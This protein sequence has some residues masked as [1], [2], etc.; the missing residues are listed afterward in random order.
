MLQMQNSL[1]TLPWIHGQFT[2]E[3][4]FNQNVSGFK[5]PTFSV[6]L[7]LLVLFFKLRHLQTVPAES[8]F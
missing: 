2:S 5:K 3:K 7:G 8:T 6:A 4:C 1:E